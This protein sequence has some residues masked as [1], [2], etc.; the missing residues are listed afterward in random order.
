MSMAQ[1]ARE[2]PSLAMGPQMFFLAISNNIPMFTDAVGNARKEYER[3]T[4]AGQKATPVWKQVLSSLFSWQTFMATAITLTVV[5]SK[6]IWELA[7]RMRKGSRAA[8][9]MADAQEK[10]NDSLDTSS[11]GRQLVTIRSLQ[12]RWNQ[13][14]NDLAEKKKFITDNKDEFDKLGVSVSNVDE[15]ENALVTNTEAFIQ[16]MTLRAEA[17]AA[18]KLAAEEAEKALKAQTEIDRK[19]RRVQAGKTRR[20]HSCSLTLNGLRAPCPTNKAHQG[21]KPSGMQ[22]SGNRM[23]LRK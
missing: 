12:E 11:L 4:A 6:E 18:F 8:L 22:V 9:E 5:Y 21:P 13:L 3:L 1:I 10:I 16:A 19:R 7:G 2:L 17:A 20:F 15:A 14:G 23:P